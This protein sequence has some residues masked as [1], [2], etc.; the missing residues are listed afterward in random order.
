MFSNRQILFYA[1]ALSFLLFQ[2]CSKQ[3]EEGDGTNGGA[4][5]VP[6]GNVFNAGGTG[7][8]G[9]PGIGS[10]PSTIIIDPNQQGQVT[11]LTPQQVTEITATA[12]NAWAVEPESLPAKLQLVVDI[13][14]SMNSAAPGTNR[15]KWEVTR[16][17]LVEAICGGGSSPGLASSTAVGLMFY[18]NM[19]NDGTAPRTAPANPNQCLNTQ[20]VTPMNVMGNNDPG[21]QRTLLRTALT[22]VELGRGTPT[23][24]AYDYALNNIVFAPNQQAFPGDTYILLITD[25]MPTLYFGCYN[26][27]G[28]L[29]NLPGDE[30]VR[31]V[32]GAFNRNVRTFIIGSPGS[33]EGKPWLSEAAF[34]GGTGMPGCAPNN[35]NGP[36]CH[37]D[38]TT[39]PDFSVA[40]RQGL[41]QVVNAVGAGCKYDVPTESADGSQKVDPNAIAP[42][43]K[44]S[45]GSS[46]LLWRDMANGAGCTEG[47]RLI[48]ATEMEICSAT[49][50]RFQADAQATMQLIFGC[51]LPD[52][53]SVIQ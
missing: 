40:L 49:C 4:S 7:S 11:P 18:P 39:A 5:A 50:A 46:E 53:I 3:S 8:T 52:L 6:T 33:E 42:I 15:S 41:N 29:S 34:L 44:Y 20:G 31:M 47:F 24:S 35:P 32:D 36:Y 17:A 9:T 1:S 51:A 14:S 27:S 13:S 16:D 2:A 38:M 45:N 12:C 26:P 30:I 37:M 25:G 22:T 10:T 19:L 43:I 48:S 21:T 23:A 28:S